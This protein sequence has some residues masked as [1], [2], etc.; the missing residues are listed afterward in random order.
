MTRTKM[1]VLADIA[2]RQRCPTC[3]AEPG[4]RCV[5]LP[6]QRAG[7]QDREISQPHSAR[8]PGGNRLIN[9]PA[10]AAALKEQP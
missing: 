4:K 5:A 3:K 7:F 1:W 10:N 6:T 2:C 8:Y 9:D